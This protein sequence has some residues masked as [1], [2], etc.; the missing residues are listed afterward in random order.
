MFDSYREIQARVHRQ[1]A[2][3]DDLILEADREIE[4]LQELLARTRRG[5]SRAGPLTLE[6]Q[7][8]AFALWE[9]GLTETEIARCLDADRYHVEQAL[10]EFRQPDSHAA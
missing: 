7:Q 4:R 8:R 9:A 5:G 3:L 1:L 6:A 10:D 2:A